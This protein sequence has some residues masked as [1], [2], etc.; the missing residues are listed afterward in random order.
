[1]TDEYPPAPP[2]RP[3]WLITLADLALLLVG[4]LVLVMATRHDAHGTLARGL[5]ARFAGDAAA[6]ATTPPPMPVAAAG[7]T[8]FAAGSAV[9]PASPDSL[10]AWAREA[11][12]DPRVTLTV[13]GSTDGSAADTDAATGNA[14]LLAADRARATAAALA[15]IVPARRLVLTTALRPGQ[16]AALVTLAFAGDPT[17]D[18]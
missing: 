11:V 16:R 18:Q 8:S 14:A 7:L 2:G 13:T 12:R 17:G 6:A 10:I 9:L 3:L 1:M 15:G 5:R 4:F